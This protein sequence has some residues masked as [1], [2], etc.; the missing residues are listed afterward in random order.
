MEDR[1][2]LRGIFKENDWI[3]PKKSDS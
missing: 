3:A 2:F 1:E